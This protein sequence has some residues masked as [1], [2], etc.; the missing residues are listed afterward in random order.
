MYKHTYQVLI[1]LTLFAGLMVPA[2]HAQSIMLKADIPFDFVVGDKR[3][4]SG[5]YYVKSLN[6]TETQIQSKDARST[7]IVMTTGMQA[8]KISD[9]G[10]LVF[11]RYGEQYFLSKIWAA[12]SDSGRQVVKSR[13]EREVAQRFSNDGTTV[14]AA[15]SV[16]KK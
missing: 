11:N 4:P 13:V 1:A 12:S 14:I 9:A 2:T 7:A 3:L 8:A 5:E 6:Q 15:K 10:K 16:P